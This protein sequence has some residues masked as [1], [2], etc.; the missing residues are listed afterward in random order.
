MVFNTIYDF[1]SYCEWP[2]YNALRVNNIINDTLELNEKQACKLITVDAYNQS[3]HFYERL[4]FEYL[5][6]NDKD[7]ETRQMYFDLTSL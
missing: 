6:E 5:T 3:L 4:N 7:E 2:F 1:F